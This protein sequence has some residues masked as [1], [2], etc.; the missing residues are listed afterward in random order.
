MVS[1]LFFG[2]LFSCCV[3]VV[4]RFCKVGIKYRG[5]PT[6]FLRKHL[7]DVHKVAVDVL[8]ASVEEDAKRLVSLVGCP[9]TGKTWCG[10]LVAHA[11]QERGKRTLHV[12]IRGNEV[13]VASEF[14]KKK[15]YEIADWNYFMLKQLLTENQCDVCIID[16]G[17]K[18][19][20]Q[21]D[22]IF[23]GVRTIL[24]SSTEPKPFPKV[25]FMGLVSGHAQENIIGKDRNVDVQKLV[26]W[27]WS[28]DDFQTRQQTVVHTR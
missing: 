12:T 26:L 25:K 19:P 9:G 10:W 15:S 22:D 23:Q 14:K 20:I 21:T 5:D 24:E 3:S 8:S 11:L 18:R 17:N 27:S 4:V 13:I 7:L 16:V 2:G 28:K 1:E 6:H